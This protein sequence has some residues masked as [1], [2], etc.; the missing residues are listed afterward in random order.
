[1]GSGFPFFFNLNG[2][3]CHPLFSISFIQNWW[4]GQF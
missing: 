4:V 2:S 1:L 3:V